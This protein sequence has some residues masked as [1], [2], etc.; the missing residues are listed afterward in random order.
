MLRGAAAGVLLWVGTASALTTSS[1][2]RSAV[3]TAS[4][5]RTAGVALQVSEPPERE[6]LDVASLSQQVQQM[7]GAGPR[8]RGLKGRASVRI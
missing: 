3:R 8:R 2:L 1:C 7:R 6:R 4:P 5:S